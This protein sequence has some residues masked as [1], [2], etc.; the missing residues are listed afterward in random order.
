M[1]AASM[2]SAAIGTVELTGL[3][4][5]AT[6]VCEYGALHPGYSLVGPGQGDGGREVKGAG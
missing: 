3:D 2:I 5:I 6:K 4:M 1:P